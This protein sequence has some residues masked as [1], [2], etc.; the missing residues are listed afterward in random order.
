MYRRGAKVQSELIGL[1]PKK[2]AVARQF[3]VQ[4]RQAA[5][6]GITG[7]IGINQSQSELIGSNRIDSDKL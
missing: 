5:K 3:G 7:Y 2:A 4:L 1:V 6:F